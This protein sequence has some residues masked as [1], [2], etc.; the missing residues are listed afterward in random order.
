MI[1]ATRLSPAMLDALRAVK[2]GANQRKLPMPT[3]RAL[4]QRGFVAGSRGKYR[5]TD[6]GSKAL[7]ANSWV[8]AELL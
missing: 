2:K 6:L 4:E 1:T 5:I 8:Q 7:E 3:M